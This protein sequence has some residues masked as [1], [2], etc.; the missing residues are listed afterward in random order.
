VLTQ[1]K[2]EYDLFISYADADEEWVEGYLL[3]ALAAA[4]VKYL[5]EKT[6]QLGVPRLTEFERAIK[7]SKRT[8]LV[9]TPA[10]LADGDTQFVDLLVATFG[11]ETSTWPI[12]PLVLK[13]VILPTR[14]AILTRLDATEQ[15]EWLDVVGKLCRTLGKGIPAPVLIPE[16]PY[17]GMKPFSE[18]ESQYFYGRSAEIEEILQRLRQHP[19]LAVSSFSIVDCT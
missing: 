10:Y 18:V 1:V 15:V 8:L 11:L 4:S 7:E 12:I 2:I 14:L 5:H 16:C 3:D 17:P 19:F 13:P 9:L 6:F